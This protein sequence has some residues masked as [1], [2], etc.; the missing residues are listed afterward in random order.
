VTPLPREGP[1]SPRSPASHAGTWVEEQEP[2]LTVTFNKEIDMSAANSTISSIANELEKMPERVEDAR[3]AL[4]GFRSDALRMVK[5]YPGRS[6][7]G[8]FAVGFVVA[9]IAKYV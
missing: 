9:K 3:K 1:R 4:D 7:L 2:A 5:K 6:L 8:A